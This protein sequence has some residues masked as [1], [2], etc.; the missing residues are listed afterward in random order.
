MNDAQR[1]EWQEYIQ[2]DEYKKELRAI[3]IILA[4]IAVL[5]IIIIIMKEP[6]YTAEQLAC[7]E[8]NQWNKFLCGV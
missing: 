1:K 5:S 8:Q 2:S 7:I 3:L 4:V 6:R